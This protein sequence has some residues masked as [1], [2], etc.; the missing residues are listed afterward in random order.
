M[1]KV[2]C[3][4]CAVSV[5]NGLPCHESGCNDAFIFTKRGKDYRRFRVWSLDVWGNEREGFEVN[6]RRE[7]GSIII[8]DDSDDKTLLKALKKKNFINKKCHFK[9]FHLDGDNLS[10]YVDWRKNGFPLYQL[11]AV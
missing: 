6:D 4:S 9:S 10:I 11:E 7:A 2:K 1:F 5:I 3:N 8:L